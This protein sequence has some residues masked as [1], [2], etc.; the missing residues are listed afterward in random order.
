MASS[1]YIVNHHIKLGI[2]AEWLWKISSN[3]WRDGFYKKYKL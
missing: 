2:A 1:L 3:G